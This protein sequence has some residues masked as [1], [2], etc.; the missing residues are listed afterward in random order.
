ML[1]ST[2]VFFGLLAHEFSVRWMK[3]RCLAV[4]ICLVTLICQAHS[5]RYCL[6]SEVAPIVFLLSHFPIDQARGE[7]GFVRTTGDCLGVA[8]VLPATSLLRPS[9]SLRIARAVEVREFAALLP[10]L[11]RRSCLLC[12]VLDLCSSSVS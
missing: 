5:E 10:L 7:K 2:H 1:Y 12:P 8:A 11:C 4:S 6:K 9:P 3:N